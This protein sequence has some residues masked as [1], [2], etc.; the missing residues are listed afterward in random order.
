[1]ESL[2]KKINEP[3]SIIFKESTMKKEKISEFQNF[4]TTKEYYC[5]NCKKK[6]NKIYIENTSI[7]C[8][9][10]YSQLCEELLPSYDADIIPPDKFKPYSSIPQEQEPRIIR[11]TNP[12]NPLVQ[13]VTDL[14]N[15]EYENDEIEN[16]LNYIFNNDNNRYGSPPASKNEIS[17]LNKY[18]LT[19]EKLKNFGGENTC[20]VCKE[21]FSVG[22]KM[23]DLPCNH[24]FHEECLMPWLN[25][26]DSCPI[27]RFELK[28][29]DDDYEKMKLQRNGNLINQNRSNNINNI[30]VTHDNNIDDIINENSNTNHI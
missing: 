13:F 15:S 6:F 27:C 21:D 18:T 30:I 4:T 25:Q 24:Y 10:C 7:E 5:Y 12:N 11:L 2:T 14:I 23:M 8:T 29:D 22:N 1:M 28:T 17:K 26:H 3:N 20:S 9:F 19:E 16:I